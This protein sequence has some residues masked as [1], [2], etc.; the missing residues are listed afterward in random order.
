MKRLFLTISA[1]WTFVLIY[2]LHRFIVLPKQSF[3]NFFVN[4]FVGHLGI[5]I[6]LFIGTIVMIICPFFIIYQKPG[7]EMKQAKL[8]ELA[9]NNYIPTYLGYFFVSMS[10]DSFLGMI[11]FYTVIVFFTYFSGI[12]YFNPIFLFVGYHIY[13]VE[14]SQG[15]QC[16]IILKTKGIIRKSETL[17]NLELY[18]INNLTYIGRKI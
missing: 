12:E 9:D 17:N 1:T 2:Y 15:V 6:F 4:Y 10:L 18:R 3:V 13:K 8:V 16:I 14:S 5:C 11:L 7:D